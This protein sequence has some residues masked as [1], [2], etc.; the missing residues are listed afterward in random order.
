VQGG[1]RGH[2]KARDA[3]GRM[4]GRV[5]VECLRHARGSG[6]EEQ[7]GQ[8]AR[9]RL[10]EEDRMPRDE[11]GGGARV[12][13]LDGPSRPL[14]LGLDRIPEPARARPRET[15]RRAGRRCPIRG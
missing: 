9:L 11:K 12:E 2:Q 3:P 6:A 10:Q 7:L 1:G 8:P 14:R 13:T 4:A 15:C 5:E